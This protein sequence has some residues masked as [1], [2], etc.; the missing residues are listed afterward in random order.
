MP[1]YYQSEDLARFTELSKT[2]PE[3]FDRYMAW[4]AHAMEDGALDGKTKRDRLMLLTA[5]VILVTL[6]NTATAYFSLWPALSS[7]QGAFDDGSIAI[8]VASEIDQERVMHFPPPVY[9]RLGNLQATVD[10]KSTHGYRT[11]TAIL[12]GTRINIQ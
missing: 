11:R 5:S 7:T 2:N 1:S 3:Q 6:P 9:D 8:Q 10:W 12:T 4:Y